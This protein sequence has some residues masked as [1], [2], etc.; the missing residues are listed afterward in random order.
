MLYPGM[1][2]SGG[3]YVCVCGGGGGGGVWVVYSK[4]RPKIVQLKRVSGRAALAH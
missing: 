1:V 4:H 3:V 2:D